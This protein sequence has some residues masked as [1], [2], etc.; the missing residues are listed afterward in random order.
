MVEG[1]GTSTQ[2]ACVVK[3]PVTGRNLLPS[4]ADVSA[5]LD[6]LVAGGAVDGVTGKSA[7][8]ID[9]LDLEQTLEMLDA[10]FALVVE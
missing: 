5:R 1:A 8:T 2:A 4:R 3:G 9:G 10:I 7:A 6:E